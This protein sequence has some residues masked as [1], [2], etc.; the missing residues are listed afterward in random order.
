MKK[1]TPNFYAVIIGT[2]I[3]NGR[4]E[5]R[6]FAFLRN[7]LLQ[8][9]WKLKASFVIEDDPLL[10]EKIFT[11]IK[12]DPKSVMFSFGGIG[13]TPDD[14]TRAIAA[15]VFGDGKLYM[16]EEAKRRI[17]DRFGKDTYPHRINMAMLPKDAKLL[18]NPINNVPGFYLHKRFFFVPGFPQMAHPMVEQVLD[19][20]YPKAPKLYRL[21]ICVE[22]SEND[23]LDIMKKIPED[24]EFSSLP[25]IED[26]RYFDVISIA[27]TDKKEAKHWMQFFINEVEKRGFRYKKAERCS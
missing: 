5:D 18:D 4:R 26:N 22:A 3:L 9:G 2:E 16:H 8:R 25:A 7:S 15:K 20:F 14:Y 13:A 21:T 19:L 1:Q 12:D 24:I 11:L 10:I 6:H 23:L 27:S 17:I